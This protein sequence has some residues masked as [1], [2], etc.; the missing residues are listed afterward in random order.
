MRVRPGCIGSRHRPAVGQRVIA[1]GGPVGW[2]QIDGVLQ[3]INVVG[4]GAPNHRNRPRS[5]AY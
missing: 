2:R 1:H 5:L 3:L 4:C